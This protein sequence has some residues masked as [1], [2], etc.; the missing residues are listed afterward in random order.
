MTNPFGVSLNHWVSIRPC[1]LAFAR[2]WNQG[3][4]ESVLHASLAKGDQGPMA[5]W[6]RFLA[7]LDPPSLRG[8][9]DGDGEV[10][11]SDF[12]ILSENFGTSGEYTGGD[13]D[14]DGQVQFSDFVILAENFGLIGGAE[15]AAVPE[16]SAVALIGLGGASRR[17]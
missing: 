17:D 3:L 14:K 4:R 13:F 16:P 8:D 15:A 2:A 6:T 11:F 5:S 1:N 7:A 9:A 12:V 10:Q